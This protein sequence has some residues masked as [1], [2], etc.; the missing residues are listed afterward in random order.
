M[1]VFDVISFGETM[2]RL[3]APVG[4][5]LE[6]TP[7]L[8]VYVGG[9]ESNT[10]TGLARLGLRT[11]WLSALPATPVGRHVDAELRRH[12][13]DTSHVVWAGEH[14]RLGIFY[15]EDAPP[16]IGARVHY[17][18]AGSACALI[19]PEAVHYE[20]VD[21]ARLLHLT[22][23]TPA[24]SNG[25]LIVFKRLI[26]RAISNNVPLSF[27]V[28]FRAKLWDS[29]V[30]SKVLEE[31]CRQA[32]LLFCTLADAAELWG[33]SGTPEEVLRQMAR[34]F[35]SPGDEKTLILTLGSE[36]SA[37]LHNDIYTI[38]PAIPTGGTVR[39]G[40]GDA[41]SAGY[42][43]AYLQGEHYRALHEQYNVTPLAF[44]NALAA[45]KRC[46]QGDIPIISPEDVRAVFQSKGGARFR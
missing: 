19:D 44:G 22:G 23:I 9:T 20:L 42:L 26:E 36:G 13:I 43:Y 15:A 16:P 27:D 40:S 46:I 38:E 39:F 10:L 12:G 29:I 4:Q 3:T 2:L 45:L 24:L 35:L 7:A 5:R 31:A 37:Q 25:T 30:A 18:R 33:F 41:F 28:N 14:A 17:D 8:E 11:A 6:T 1:P 34:R 32:R 21:E